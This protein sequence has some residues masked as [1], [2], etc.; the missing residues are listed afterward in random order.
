MDIT[1][2]TIKLA[3]LF[4]PG[5]ISASIIFSLITRKKID[6]RDYFVSVFLL[7][8]ASYFF[9]NISQNIVEIIK[10][11][12]KFTKYINSKFISAI[13]D[14]TN[15]ISYKEILYTCI[16]AIIIGITIA[17]LHNSKIL[18][19]ISRKLKLTN[20]SSG[21]DVWDSLFAN[22]GNG[23]KNWIYVIDK[24]LDLVYGGWV[25]EYSQDHSD[26]ELL[27]KDVVCY[28]NSNRTKKLRSMDYVY[29]TKN[30][31]DIII[32]MRGEENE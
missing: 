28:K 29:I 16:I 20:K 19:K 14:N 2:T 10:N 1:V 9:Q 23:I 15:E 24:D 11:N 30:E 27:L 26:I 6:N 13:F 7:T 4:L 21:L 22:A 17:K 8:F 25:K 32:E 5:I 12:F 31:K 3:I 18:Y